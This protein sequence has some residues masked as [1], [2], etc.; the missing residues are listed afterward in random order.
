[1]CDE[2]GV[3]RPWRIRRWWR[4]RYWIGYCST[5]LHCRTKRL[6]VSLYVMHH[7]GQTRTMKFIG[8]YIGWTTT[9]R[10]IGKLMRLLG[11]IHLLIMILHLLHPS[12][13][14][15]LPGCL[16]LLKYDI[17]N[18]MSIHIYEW[19]LRIKKENE[20]KQIGRASCRERVSSPV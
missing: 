18:L 8:K 13:L 17:V 11:F 6:Q 16:H 7:E 14:S 9:H 10:H 3:A 1:M 20:R 15:L 12:F 5:I 4:S 19:E 2:I